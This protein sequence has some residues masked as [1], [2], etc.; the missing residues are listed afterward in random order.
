M[1]L[2]ARLLSDGLVDVVALVAN[3]PD[4]VRDPELEA[5]CAVGRQELDDVLLLAVLE[6]EAHEALRD[7]RL[8]VRVTGLAERLLEQSSV[9]RLLL[10]VVVFG[11]DDGVVEL[12]AAR[13]LVFLEQV[14]QI[15]HERVELGEAP[16]DVGVDLERLLHRSEQVSAALR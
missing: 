3:L 10:R 4:L 12:A 15:A 6:H 2:G 14:A 8:L 7:R 13:V 5:I 16:R 1:L 11:L 9:L